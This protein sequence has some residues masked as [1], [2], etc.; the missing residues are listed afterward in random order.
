MIGVGIIGFGRWGENLVRAFSETDG[1]RV[2]AICDHLEERR[3]LA[4]AAYPASETCADASTLFGNPSI[5]AVVIATPA[6]SHFELAVTAL[7]ADKHVFVEKPIAATSREAQLLI[8]VADARRRTLMVDH[9]P[10][11]SAAVEVVRSLIQGGTIGD[12]YYYDAVRANFGRVRHDVNVV[13]DLAVHD[14][15]IIDFI[16]NRQPQMISAAGAAHVAVQ[17]QSVAYLTCF[18]EGNMIAHVHVNWLAPTKVRRTMVGGSKGVID[19]DDT[20]PMDKLRIYDESII[21]RGGSE[22]AD[23]LEIGY[24]SAGMWTPRLYDG[25]ALH[26]ATRHFVNCIQTG[27]RPTTDGSSGLRVVRMLEAASRSLTLGGSL[28]P[29]PE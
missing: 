3:A 16:F 21:P 24:R 28:I 2:V 9:T 23:Q 15:A 11:Y 1:A 22:E 18:F 14:L 26:V 20:L 17:L 10:C 29:L 6:S 27:R 4:Q 13:W 5:S 8:D 19:W 7:H 12:V 25:Q